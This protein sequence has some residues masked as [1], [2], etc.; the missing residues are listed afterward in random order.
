MELSLLS[1]LFKMQCSLY[2][3]P[4][5]IYEN[6]VRLAAFEPFTIDCDLITRYLPSLI[7]TTEPL[8]YLITN[9]LL[10][11]GHVR[12]LTS[13]YDIIIGPVQISK[14]TE[15]NIKSII[16]KYRL[17]IGIEYIHQIEQFFD[18]ARKY[19]FD[20]F[21]PIICI[22][23]GFINNQL[24]SYSELVNKADDKSL[25]EDVNMRMIHAVQEHTYDEIPRRNNYNLE[26]E[27]MFYISHGMT[28]KIN[29]MS[30]TRHDMPNLA[31]DSLRHYKNA[32]IIL[33]TL[34]Q[35]AA[36]NGGLDPETSY[37]L[38]EIY[39]QKIESARDVNTLTNISQKLLIDYSERVASFKHPQTNHDKINEAMHYIRENCQKR[40]MVEDIAEIVG[41]SKEYL[42]SKFIQATGITLPNYINQQKITEAKQL[43]H[44][45][46]LSL[47][48][49]AE[50]L[51]FSSQSYFQSIF[52][53]MT[54][55]TPT[56]YRK[57]SKQQI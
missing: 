30:F 22:I 1:G 6:N 28:D 3:I 14:I 11:F 48:E 20:Q 5:Y 44:F 53:N 26:S 4:F 21:I 37:Q 25:N 42:S 15:T 45:T 54:G 55:Y 32:V 39:I 19:S 36:I 41:L 13:G 49:I 57:Q 46:D 18:A 8:N 50:Y 52:K 43:L 12:D 35:R 17:A 24:V 10:M 38:G 40:L 27:I 16:I 33:N 7:G 51:S 2:H 34:S 9:D 31:S 47:S 56:E 29:K 23:H